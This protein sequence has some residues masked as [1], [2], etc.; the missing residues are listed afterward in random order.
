MKKLC[1]VLILF[2]A[3]CSAN[4]DQYKAK[5]LTD[6][7]IQKINSGAYNELS[8]YYTD[9]LNEGEP[10]A[11]RTEKFKKLKD[12]LGDVVSTQIVSE[13]DSTTQDETNCIILIYNVKHT[14]YTS[15]EE[16]TV[17]K[18]GGSYKVSQQKID[19]E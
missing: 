8:P 3:A 18:Q 10:I 15:R 4:L 12:V 19:K 2:L 7:L 17:V 14:K 9:E 11:A 13:K 1:G 16:F 5:A 6:E